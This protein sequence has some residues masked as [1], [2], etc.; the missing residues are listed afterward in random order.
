V[1]PTQKQLIACERW[2]LV[3]ALHRVAGGSDVVAQS[4]GLRTRQRSKG[5]WQDFTNLRDELVAFNAQHGQLGQMPSP[6]LLREV[7]FSVLLSPINDFGGFFA[8]AERLGWSCTNATLWPRS[9]I[10]IGI[11]HELQCVVDF[12]PDY[13]KLDSIKGR[14]DCDIVMP[15]LSLVVEFDSWK[16]H[17]GKNNKGVDRYVKDCEKSERLRDAGWQVIRIRERPLALTHEHDVGVGGATL[18]QHVDAVVHRMQQLYPTLESRVAAYLSYATPQR[19]KESR[20][21]IGNILRTRRGES[22]T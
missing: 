15:T 3:N 11:A 16:W 14:P 19:V 13:H 2:D 1:M 7:G 5:Y 4:L 21:Y 12:D 20:I 10:E 6:T 9:E 18:K 17:H 22:A 8:V